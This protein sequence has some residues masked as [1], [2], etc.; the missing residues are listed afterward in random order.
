MFTLK[1]CSSTSGSRAVTKICE[2]VFH[3][4]SFDLSLTIYWVIVWPFSGSLM[5]RCR[6]S[7][8]RYTGSL[9]DRFESLMDRRRV[10]HWRFTGFVL[11]DYAY[12][13]WLLDIAS[14]GRATCIWIWKEQFSA[15]RSFTFEPSHNCDLYSAGCIA[16]SIDSG[17]WVYLDWS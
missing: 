8:W 10:H 11:I 13:G 12:W 9:G 3:R 16:M 5:D 1:V 6:V 7:H 4:T 17:S 2:T 15:S 14:S